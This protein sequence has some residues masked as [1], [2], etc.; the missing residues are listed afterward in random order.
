MF[1]ETPI[2]SPCVAAF[3]FLL[4][5]TR[6]K[7]INYTHSEKVV[8][9][10]IKEETEVTVQV[11]VEYSSFYECWEVIVTRVDT[12]EV[13]YGYGENFD[14]EDDAWD[15]VEWFLVGDPELEVIL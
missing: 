15:Y 5:T 10:P 4:F 14:N 1:C 6:L 7:I 2:K 13:L 9:R 8:I 3:L 11:E 12:R